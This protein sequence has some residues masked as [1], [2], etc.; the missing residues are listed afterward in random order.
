[1]TIMH[2]IR[3]DW[4][5]SWLMYPY[6]ATTEPRPTSKL[7]YTSKV[8]PFSLSNRFLHPPSTSAV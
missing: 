6:S 4:I 5:I 2:F 7:K 1:M 3:I 8:F